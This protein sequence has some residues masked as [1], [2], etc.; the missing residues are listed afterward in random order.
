MAKDTFQFTNINTL[1]EMGLQ[2]ITPTLNSSAEK[3]YLGNTKYVRNIIDCQTH[4]DCLDCK[5]YCPCHG[6]DVAD[7]H[8][9][10]TYEGGTE[11]VFTKRQRELHLA[12]LRTVVSGSNNCI[13]LIR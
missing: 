6:I 1:K 4:T 11:D 7:I 9:S 12:G 3:C 13:S 5:Q 8:G 10:E 2:R